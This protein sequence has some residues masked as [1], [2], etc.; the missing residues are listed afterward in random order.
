M[1]SAIAKTA[2]QCERAYLAKYSESSWVGPPLP[3]LLIQF[4]YKFLKSLRS[5]AP[6][7]LA[8]SG[9]TSGCLGGSVGFSSSSTFV[10]VSSSK[11]GNLFDTDAA[12]ASEVFDDFLTNLGE[13]LGDF[14]IFP[15]GLFWTEGGRFE[16][17]AIIRSKAV[18]ERV[19]FLWQGM[20]SVSTVKPRFKWKIHQP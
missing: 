13:F 18:T 14:R 12:A 20:V 16:A 5:R 4:L 3:A 10:F 17:V 6:S 8:F 1:H 19:V 7:R 9:K 11:R 15:A 2:F